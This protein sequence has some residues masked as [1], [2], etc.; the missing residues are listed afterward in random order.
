MTMKTE[1]PSYKA[2]KSYCGQFLWKE[3]W[4]GGRGNAE[5]KN[6]MQRKR[7]DVRFHPNIDDVSEKKGMHNDVFATD[8]I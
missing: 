3:R 1:T 8:G 6:Q 2:A 5:V 4:T 7:D